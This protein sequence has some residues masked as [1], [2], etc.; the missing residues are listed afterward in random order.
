MLGFKGT[1]EIHLHQLPAQTDMTQNSL[2]LTVC[3][4][5]GGNTKFGENSF[6]KMIM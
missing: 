4:L 2:S 5:V 3:I 1:A 6:Q